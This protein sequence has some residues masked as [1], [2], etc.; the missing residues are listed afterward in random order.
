MHYAIQNGV[1]IHITDYNPDG[2][3]LCCADPKCGA[4]LYYQPTVR[5]NGSERASAHFASINRND[6]RENCTELSLD[7]EIREES[8]SLK[9]AVL[10]GRHII[11]SLNDLFGLP[12]QLWVDF[13]PAAK[14]QKPNTRLQAFKDS[15]RNPITGKKGHSSHS[16]RTIKELISHI[17]RIHNHGHDAAL[18]KTWITWQDKT[19]PFHDFYLDTEASQK[20]YFRDLYN[21]SKCGNHFKFAAHKKGGNT[22]DMPHLYRFRPS[23]LTHEDPMSGRL[24]SAA[25]SLKEAHDQTNVPLILQHNVNMGMASQPIQRE[26]F[27]NDTFVLAAMS[28]DIIRTKKDVCTYNKGNNRPT[29]VILRSSVEGDH[30]FMPAIGIILPRPYRGNAPKLI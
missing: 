17:K 16:I 11:L 29:F 30:Q 8:L 25:I 6:H 5:K 3:D 13:A 28:I 23:R 12:P 4:Q 20:Q 1:K 27:A 2:G 15:L 21:Q 14:G 18:H 10:K 24:A 26:I 7:L 19:I 22:W 9:Q